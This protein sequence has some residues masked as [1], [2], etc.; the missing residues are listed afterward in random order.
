MASTSNTNHERALLEGLHHAVHGLRAP[1]T[2]GGT[3]VPEQAVTLCFPDN[4]QIAVLRARDTFEEERLLRPLVERCTAA[5]FGMGRKTR[6]DR[7][8]RDALQIKAE[9]GAFSVLHFDPAAAGILERIRRELAPHIPDAL[10]AE[11]Y[12]L[13]VYGRGGHFVPH[14]DTPRGS[15]MLG[16]LV[17]CLPSQFSNGALV[18]KH[19]GVFQTFNWGE[20]I[21]QQTEPTRLHWAAFFGDVDHQIERVWSGLRVTL[22]YLLRRSLGSAPLPVVAPEVVPTLVQDKLR[23]LLA[24]RRFLPRGGTLA[25]PCAHLYHQDARFQQ[26]APPLS[27]QTVSA[28]K[29]RDYLV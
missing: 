8:V 10:T 3:L 12:N 5:A 14:K 21:R 6:Y 22:T 28:L 19:Q 2:C 26:Q 15:D 17:V 20:A 4:T 1:F 25:F 18:V 23:A 16:T 27:P 11:L 29:G 7:T 24:A 13:N 9:G